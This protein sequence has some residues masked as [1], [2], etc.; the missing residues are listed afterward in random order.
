MFP[1]RNGRHVVVGGNYQAGTWVTDFTDPANPVT[2]AW[3]DPPR[4]VPTQVGGAWSS[5]WYNNFIYESEITKG[6]NVFRLADPAVVG[7]IS[8]GHL[9]P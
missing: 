7:A 1:L 4:L 5:Y 9:N 8:L 2:V 6:M 3:S